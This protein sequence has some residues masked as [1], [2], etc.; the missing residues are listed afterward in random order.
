MHS[1]IE[2]DELSSISQDI[3]DKL[4]S[5]RLKLPASPEV[6]L[7]VNALLNDDT[8]GL[9][10]IAVAL[11]AHQTLAARLL[12]V[13]NSPALHP[14]KPI[15]SLHTALCILG[16][17]LVKNLAISIAIRDMFRSKNFELKVL[18]DATWHHSVEVGVLMSLYI[19]HIEDRRYDPN[20]AL[21]IGILHSIGC[22]PII[23]YFEIEKLPVEKY[24]AVEKELASA[25]SVSL[26]KEWG[27]PAS[28]AEAIKGSPGMYSDVLKYVHQYLD[29][30]EYPDMLMPFEEFEKI[31]NDNTDKYNGLVSV[32]Q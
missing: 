19:N 27:L 18:L 28:F 15:A 32:Y 25:I 1:P 10:D 31:V 8:K 9:S 6:V 12:Q 23:D 14:I 2:Q 29:K 7:K 21:V 4:T 30:E 11:E 3:I 13:V 24:K 20:I 17:A 26:V 5:K 16:I 22:L